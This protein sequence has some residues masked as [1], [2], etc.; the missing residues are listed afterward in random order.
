[1]KSKIETQLVFEIC[2]IVEK[3]LYKV[4]KIF[5]YERKLNIQTII[6]QVFRRY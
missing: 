5:N 1:M 2:L 3:N 4:L 6:F